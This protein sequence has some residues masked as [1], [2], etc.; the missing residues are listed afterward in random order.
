MCQNRKAVRDNIF[1]KSPN[2]TMKN[3]NWVDEED[4]IAIKNRNSYMNHITK[5][6]Y[7]KQHS[8]KKSL[9]LTFNC[10]PVNTSYSTQIVHS[11][12]SSSST[13][14]PRFNILTQ[15]ANTK[16]DVSLHDM[17]TILE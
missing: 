17:V 5:E 10:S 15:M 6:Q 2:P 14:L 12:P 7:F 11:F 13:K 9:D 4:F 8:N 3:L 1:G 16:T